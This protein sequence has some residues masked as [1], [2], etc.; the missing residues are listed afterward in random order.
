MSKCRRECPG[1][2]QPSAQIVRVKARNAGESAIWPGPLR[3]SCVSRARN[4]GEGAFWPGPAQPSAEIA[5][6]EGAKCRR[7]CVEGAKCRRECILARSGATLCGNHACRG[8]ETQAR[9]RFGPLRHN[10]LR[11][12]KECPARASHKSDPQERERER[13]RECPTGSRFGLKLGREFL[14]LRLTQ[15]GPQGQ[16]RLFNQDIEQ[17]GLDFARDRDSVALCPSR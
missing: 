15:R 8:R 7:A 4:A 1:R 11:R 2:G 9:V 17:G 14:A 13:E 3:R 6:V 5:R 12:S 16:G 10:P